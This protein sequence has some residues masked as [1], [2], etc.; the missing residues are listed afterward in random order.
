MCCYRQICTYVCG[1][2]VIEGEL[3]GSPI[4]VFLNPDSNRSCGTELGTFRIV[5]TW[6]AGLC[7]KCSAAN[8]EARRL[9][10]RGLERAATQPEQETQ[11][12][13][14]VM[15]KRQSNVP[16]GPPAA[17]RLAELNDLAVA[18]LERYFMA[19][20]Q[21]RDNVTHFM[22]VLMFVGSLPGWINRSRLV[23]ELEPWFATTFDEDAQFCIRPCLRAMG[24]EHTL[25]DVMVWK[26]D[27]P[28]I[29]A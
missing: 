24:R 19:N 12:R 13:R 28:G 22:W 1:H 2:E 14:R 11:A 4:C 21:V 23:D 3:R 10:F 26:Y 18:S 27:G 6:A 17:P 20:P 9:G 5:E 25:D 7:E 15:L 29:S 8:A 16:P